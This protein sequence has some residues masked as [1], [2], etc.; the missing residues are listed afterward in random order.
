M[1]ERI[2]AEEKLARVFAGF[3]PTMVTEIANALQ[4]YHEQWYDELVASPPDVVMRAQGK[5]QAIQIIIKTIMDSR[6]IIEKIDTRR[7]VNASTERPYATRMGM[8]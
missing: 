5:V 3:S 1:S 6:G 7:N 2:K 8:M 4:A